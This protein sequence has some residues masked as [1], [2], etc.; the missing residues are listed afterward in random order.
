MKN[1]K[2]ILPVLAAILMTS[3]NAFTQNN[4]NPNSF[5]QLY[6]KMDY[7]QMK[8]ISNGTLTDYGCFQSADG[9]FIADLL[10]KKGLPNSTTKLQDYT[11]SMVLVD[12][13]VTQNGQPNGQV[14][15]V[16]IKKSQFA[17]WCQIYERE[18]TPKSQQLGVISVAKGSTWYS[19]Q[20]DHVSTGNMQTS[21]NF[22]TYYKYQ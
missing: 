16:A 18:G 22:G 21:P 4:V 8:Q 17:M 2:L 20:I 11:K 1:L 15:K 5:N 19:D 10:T 14:Q 7:Y 12:A 13:S 6:I 3:C 9:D